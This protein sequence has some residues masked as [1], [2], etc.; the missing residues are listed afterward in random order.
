[1]KQV[2]PEKYDKEY[3]EHVFQSLDYS[4][5]VE[6]GSFK[7]IYRT[8]GDMLK[9]NSRDT[10]VDFGCGNGDLSFYL[11]KKYDCNVMGIDYSK[12]AVLLCKANLT[13]YLIKNRTNSSI[14]FKNINNDQLPKLTNITAV[15]FCDVLEHM[16][17]HE[18]QLVLN[19][20]ANWIKDGHIYLVVHTDN[21]IY[22]KVIRPFIDLL[23]II[24]GSESFVSLRK[25]N[26][27]EKERH[28]NLTNPYKLSKKMAKWGYN[29]NVLK[30]PTASLSVI[31]KQLGPL[32][33]NKIFVLVIR[34]VL[35]KLSFLSP[36]FYVIYEKK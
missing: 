5:E 16:Y 23:S 26:S 4:K 12:D 14:T 10:V 13:K 11:N 27:W 1:M 28:I 20:V 34:K 22:Q 18:I 31:K 6:L 32:G 35:R 36:T 7:H 30:F 21:N 19:Q 33:N 29:E 9:I 2:K 17:D 8:M 25:R 15:Y 3:F 24:A